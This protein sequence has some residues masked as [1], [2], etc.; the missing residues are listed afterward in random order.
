MKTRKAIALF[1]ILLL[2]FTLASCSKAKPSQKTTEPQI[3]Q[4]KS[5]CDLATMECYYH[6]VAK[7][8]EEDA[9]GILLWKKD[10]HFWIEYSGIIKLGIDFSLLDMKLETNSVKITIPAAKVLSAKVDEASL[11]EES[12]VIDKSS[13]KISAQD[14]TTAFSEAQKNMVLAA[15]K[16]SALLLSAQQRA[17]TL[18]E[19]YIA[20]VGE[21]V[22]KEYSVTW[23]YL[24]A[25]GNSSTNTAEESQGTQ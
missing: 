23:I 16:D 10:K 20:N 14:Q 9:E 8:N 25:N 6:N 3:S 17:Q 22:G 11:S 19:K 1:L 2:S 21:A 7:Y 12:F 24:D 13:A 5:I 15:S 18:L 4:M